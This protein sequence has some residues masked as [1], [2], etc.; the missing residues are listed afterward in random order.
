VYG[1]LVICLYVLVLGD[2]V[3]IKCND[4]NGTP[5][6]IHFLGVVDRIE[7]EAL[8]SWPDSYGTVRDPNAVGTCHLMFAH[9]EDR[10]DLYDNIFEAMIT[11]MPCSVN[12][13]ELV[14]VVYK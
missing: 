6:D 12:I 5:S 3:F 9:K 13:F 7:K 14:D 1:N 11:S 2:P 8:Q 4:E 10:D